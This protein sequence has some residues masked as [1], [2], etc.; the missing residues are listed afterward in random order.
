MFSQGLPKRLENH[1][2]HVKLAFDHQT[3]KIDE[4]ATALV[5]GSSWHPKNFEKNTQVSQ[6]IRKRFRIVSES[7]FPRAPQMARK[8]LISCAA[9]ANNTKNQSKLST[10]PNVHLGIRRNA[11]V[12]FDPL[13]IW[14]RTLF[15]E[16][17][18]ERLENDCTD[19]KH[20]LTRC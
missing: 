20:V 11:K 13:Y 12:P 5:H 2:T 19:K 1:F 14:L 6:I 15:F 16:R 17:L 9:C 4:F 18:L 10:I 3:L 8:Q 7:T